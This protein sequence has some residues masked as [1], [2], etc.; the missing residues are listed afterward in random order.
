MPSRRTTVFSP[1]TYGTSPVPTTPGAIRTRNSQTNSA[2]DRAPAA[3]VR[4]GPAR[5]ILLCSRSPA[6][7]WAVD[8]MPDAAHL[9]ELQRIQVRESD[10]I[11]FHNYTWPEYF[12]RQ[13]AWLK[14]YRRP[15]ICTEDMARPAGQHVRRDP[16]DR[17][18]GKGGL[19]QLGVRRREDA[20]LSAVGLVAASLRPGA[21]TGVVSRGASL[22][23]DALSGGGSAFDP[24]AHGRALGTACS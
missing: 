18:T 21:T 14:Q 20:D 1:G 4:L 2:G 19:D 24:A 8:T 16:A 12:T 9:G 6:A 13:V 5:R 23:W 11:T 15:V 22:R 3:D 10:I 7:S 17:Q